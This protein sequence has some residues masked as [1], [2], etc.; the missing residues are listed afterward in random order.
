MFS[1]LTFVHHYNE[2]DARLPTNL[3][4]TGVAQEDRSLSSKFVC[5]AKHITYFFLKSIGTVLPRG[6]GNFKGHR[7]ICKDDKVQKPFF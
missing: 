6:L 1:T 5:Q 7:N 2:R 4:V 3:P